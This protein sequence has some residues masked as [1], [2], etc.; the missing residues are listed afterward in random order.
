MAEYNT[1]EFRDHPSIAPIINS[2]LYRHRVSWSLFS[3]LQ[4]EVTKD[5]LIANEGKRWAD[6]STTAE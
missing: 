4:E 1:H 6:R 2:H 5:R 3:E